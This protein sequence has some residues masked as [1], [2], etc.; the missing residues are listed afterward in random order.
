MATTE[1]IRKSSVQGKGA[2]RKRV[3][4]DGGDFNGGDTA[5]HVVGRPEEQPARKHAPLPPKPKIINTDTIRYDMHMRMEQL[6]PAL[7]EVRVLE[8]LLAVIEEEMIA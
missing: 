6:E 5:K 8:R 7:S 1:S 4:L 3:S 2:K